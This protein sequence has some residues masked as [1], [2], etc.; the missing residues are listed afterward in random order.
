MKE[1]NSFLRTLL[2]TEVSLFLISSLTLLFTKGFSNFT[3]SFL[4][5]YSVMALD[6]FLLARFSKRVSQLVSL[7]HF[8]R[9]GFLWRFLAVALIL[10]GISLFTQVDFFAIIS[11]VATANFGLFLAVILSRKEW[12]KWNTEA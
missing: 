9:S 10:F 7:G 5:G 8:P 6:L 1:F 11:A 3:L 4:V 2:V 12:E